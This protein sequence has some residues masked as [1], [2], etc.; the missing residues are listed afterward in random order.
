V[1][2][3]YVFGVRHHGPGSA[4][5]VAS[6][7]DGVRPDIVLIEGAP[8]LDAVAA[9]VAEPGM[10]PPVAALV[11]APAEPRRAT[12]YPLAS[13]SPE[14][15]A[16]RW[17][18]E[19]GVPVRFADLP[20]ATMLADQA[21]DAD[22]DAAADE[23]EPST[24]DPIALLA[25][26][27]GFDDPERWWEDAV[28]HRHHGLGAFDAVR[29]AMAE[30]RTDGRLARHRRLDN[31]RREAAMRMAVR[32]A[33]KD[34]DRVVFV[35]GAWHAPAVHPDAHPTAKHDQDLLRGLAK[36]K[37]AATWVPW[38]NRRL[39]V[40]SGY[41][42]GV[43]SPGWYEHLF[44]APGDV[45]A[46]WLTRTASLLRAEQIDASTASVIEGVRLADALAALRGRP[47]AGLAELTDATEAVLCGGSSL[48]LRLVADKL[49]VGDALGAVPAT[50]PMVPLARDL[51]RLQKRLRLKPSA[52]ERLVMLDLRTDTHMGRSHL[53]HRL[54]LLGVPW[55]EQVD[56]GGTRGTFKEA[57][58]LVWDPELS[59]ALIDA[60]GLGTTVAEAAAAV[61]A[62][63][64]G[65]ADVARLT[66][67]VEDALL[68]D[69]P[70]ALGAVM[71]ALVERSA[72]QHD[73]EVLMAA[74]EPLA[75]VSRYGNVRQVDTDAVLGVLHGIAVRVCIGLGPACSSLDDDA[76][77]HMRTL[78]DRVQ[79]GLAMVDD[80]DLRSSWFDA[81]AAVADQHGVHGTIAGRTVRLLLD[82]GRVDVDDA[83]RRLSR[84]LSRGADA[85]DA[86]A[87]LDGFLS[88]D[89]ALLLHD[90]GLLAVIDAWVAEAGSG[91]FDDLLPLLRRTFSAFPS[92]ERRM[93]GD[94]V[95]GLDGRGSAPPGHSAVAGD[96]TIDIERARRAVPL[97]RRILGVDG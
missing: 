36:V 26:A 78:V 22:A 27:A 18:F 41:G 52:V 15:V 47:L 75:R 48:P 54:R 10:A 67:L 57:W 43:V 16:L 35:C 33:A 11:Y 45:T 86:A 38:T 64:V 17:A 76:A 93:I 49:F 69:L 29:D 13:F 66:S 88:G 71:A 40:A 30:L 14:W 39:A 37:V 68:A 1:S 9:L 32:A 85:V 8:E 59:V 42:A 24:A 2:D 19:A 6:G 50:T 56:P 34:H 70:D 3:V 23:G 51:E 87:W 83:G 91:L 12:F 5:A 28:E 46:R 84:A 82:G 63:R 58:R 62:Q 55:G 4:R 74:V 92:P 94:K 60:S 73:T 25:G 90:D 81:L 65:D 97:L 77:T 20:A 72:R 89:A 80:A 53:L 21:P 96:E 7:L 61:V 44:S 79:R 31:T 95:R